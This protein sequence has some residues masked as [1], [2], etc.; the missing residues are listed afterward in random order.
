MQY[1]MPI[2]IC[3]QYL[4]KLPDVTMSYKSTYY[5]PSA[6]V[7]PPKPFHFVFYHF[8]LCI[9]HN[10]IEVHVVQLGTVYT[11]AHKILW[12]HYPFRA[13]AIE[14]VRT[15]SARWIKTIQTDLFRGNNKHKIENIFV[16][17][18]SVFSS[19]F[20]YLFIMIISKNFISIF[21]RWWF[22]NVFF[23]LCT[24]QIATKGRNRPN[25]ISCE[26]FKFIC[27]VLFRASHREQITEV[28]FHKPLYS[29]FAE[30]LFSLRTHTFWSGMQK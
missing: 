18:F 6:L 22:R 9:Q 28:A 29:L 25:E 3:I 23:C 2:A 8:V 13:I 16:W 30:F 20:L 11:P 7:A 17:I 14:I 27:F 15:E 1:T 4:E 12:Y 19:I 24:T 5:T 26:K 21:V 10:R